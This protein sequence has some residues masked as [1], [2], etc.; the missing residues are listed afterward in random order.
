MHMLST[1]DHMKKLQWKTYVFWIV[2][3]ESVGALS[4]WLTRE[5]TKLYQASIVQPPLSPP[6]LVFPI[7]WTIL[8]ALMGIGA[9][10]VY[11]S[12]ASG[13]RSQALLRYGVQLLFNFF[14]SII[15]FNLQ[16]FGAAFLWLAALWVL[17]LRMILSFRKADPLAAWLQLPYL[18]WVTFAGY[19][20]L[21]VW[22][23]NS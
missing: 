17:I 20:N 7:V 9:A 22:L 6:G 15:F 16:A 21:G 10:R 2:L 19:L 23:L 8:Y 1:G 3:T 11:L 4:G 13:A 14:W 18:L 5:G 12:P